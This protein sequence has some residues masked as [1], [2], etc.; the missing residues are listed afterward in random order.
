M[1]HVLMLILIYLVLGACAGVI[2]GTLGVGGGLLIVPGLAW[3]FR[4]E[5]FPSDVVMH[6]AVGT[7][8]AIMII[9]TIRAIIAHRRYE[10][11]F[12]SIYRRML[13]GIIIGVVGGGVLGHF[14]HSRMIAIL[15]GAFVLLMSIGMFFM[16]SIDPK[17]QLPGNVSMGIVGVIAGILSGLLGIGGGVITIPYLTYC[18]VKMRQSLLISIATALTVS[19][20]GTLTVMITG[21]Y[22]P[23]L[24]AWSTGYVYWP[25]WLGASL[26]TVFSVPLGVKLS[27]RLPIPVLKHVFAVFLLLIGVHLLFSH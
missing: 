9:S 3:I 4:L 16:K 8:L 19:L 5:H 6:M 1:E 21:M 17:R 12:W 24:P 14:L 23:D 22:T 27:Y 18:N 15:F 25:A 10:T 2:F 20:F 13:I 11:E 7:S 26:G